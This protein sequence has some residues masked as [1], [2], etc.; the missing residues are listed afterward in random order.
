MWIK[1]PIKVCKYSH[2]NIPSGDLRFSI[3]SYCN[4]N[5]SYCHNEGGRAK[6]E[7]PFKD[8]MRIIEGAMNY[9]VKSIRL[10]GGEPLIHKDIFTICQEIKTKY[11][12]VSLGVNTNAV[13][14]HT[15]LQLITLGYLNKIAVGIDYF[16]AP[17]SK[18]SSIGLSSKE[19]L[20]NIMRIKNAGG[21]VDLSVVYNG[22]LDTIEKLVEWCFQKNIF[23]KILE[24]ITNETA[25]Q[26][27]KAY[28]EMANHI[29]D[30]YQLEVRYNI[31]KRKYF[32]VS[33]NNNGIAFLNSHCRLRECEICARL[34]M[35]VSSEGSARVCLY[36][37]TP[38]FSLL[39]D[40]MFHRN[41]RAAVTYLGTSPE[42]YIA[43]SEEYKETPQ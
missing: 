22:D 23:I 3:T 10:T 7:L 17:I 9:G 36:A 11:P 39:D 6:N 5:C 31:T 1:S 14:I 35:R 34:H 25:S 43:M 30:R 8:V 29:I 13:E 27:D 26:P 33:S 18:N 37:N 16:D 4:M 28:Q 24:I 42:K 32:A 15:L 21:N 2:L 40:E 20:D 38:D 12:H 19:I 41:F